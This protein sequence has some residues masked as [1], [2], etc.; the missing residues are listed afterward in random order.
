MKCDHCNN[1]AKVILDNSNNLCMDC[2]NKILSE[3]Y[4]CECFNEFTRE[5]VISEPD[6]TIH[7]F[8]IEQ[9]LLGKY[10]YWR[11]YEEGG[12]EFALRVDTESNQKVAVKRL[13]QKILKGISAKSMQIGQSQPGQISNAVY[14]GNLE[15]NLNETGLLRIEDDAD[16]K[17]YIYMDGIKLTGEEF[18]KML[19]V[20]NGF[21]M[22]WRF[23]DIADDVDMP[24]KLSIT[25]DRMEEY[26]Q[27]FESMIM[28]FAEHGSFVSY[29]RSADLSE[30]IFEYLDILEELIRHGNGEDAVELGERIINRLK[31][32]E[33]DDDCFPIYEIESVERILER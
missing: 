15:Y 30:E 10:T 7:T 18:L 23:L 12:Y 21:N 27:K 3:E 32:L 25:K 28:R 8:E 14:R 33:T 9:M 5:I 29:K 2:Y 16:G 6:G 17:I 26:W 19:T 22:E 1:E 24:L 20:Y 31:G 11:A 4:G 13:H